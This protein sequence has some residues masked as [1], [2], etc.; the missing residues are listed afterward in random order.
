[1][2]DTGF[3]GRIQAY[4]L[5]QPWLGRVPKV[6]RGGEGGA[7]FSMETCNIKIHDREHRFP[8]SAWQLPY[9]VLDDTILEHTFPNSVPYQGV[10]TLLTVSTLVL[11]FD[12]T[13]RHKAMSA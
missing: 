2:V 3:P 8:N 4:I 7:C 11:T 5:A 10:V 1:M 6:R 13:K 12:E 9:Q